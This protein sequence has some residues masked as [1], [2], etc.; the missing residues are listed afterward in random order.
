MDQACGMN[1]ER[2]NAH[3][4][5]VEK[6]GGSATGKTLQRWEDNIDIDVEYIW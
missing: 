2:G 5:Y 1:R 4:F 3:M 6:Y